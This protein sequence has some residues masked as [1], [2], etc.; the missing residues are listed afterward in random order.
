VHRGDE[1]RFVVRV[2]EKINS[3]LGLEAAIAATANVEELPHKSRQRFLDDDRASLK[4]RSV[5]G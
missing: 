3:F 1:G 4:P 5:R 2:D